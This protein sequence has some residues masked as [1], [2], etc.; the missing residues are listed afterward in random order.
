MGD[1]SWMVWFFVQFP[2]S[3]LKR[4]FVGDFSS[5]PLF[6]ISYV[7]CSMWSME[8]EKKSETKGS[9]IISQK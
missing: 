5:F 7:Q 6:E 3:V 9:S 8:M 2:K 4:M 1:G